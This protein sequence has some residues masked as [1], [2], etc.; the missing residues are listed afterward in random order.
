M[1]DKKV[2]NLTSAPGTGK[3]DGK[4]V[5]GKCILHS[6]SCCTRFWNRH[7]AFLGTNVLAQCSYAYT[8]LIARKTI[9][10]DE[11]WHESLCLHR[12]LHRPGQR[13]SSPRQGSSLSARKTWWWSQHAKSCRNVA[14][15]GAKGAPND[16][17]SVCYSWSSEGLLVSRWSRGKT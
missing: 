5:P 16:R 8:L 17:H 2:S 13:R 14:C 15:E 1:E 9:L 3:D 4:A 12:R 10:I 11:H 6:K 7:W